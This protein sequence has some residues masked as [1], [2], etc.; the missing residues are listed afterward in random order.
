MADW[1]EYGELKNHANELGS[2]IYKKYD[3]HK[4][5]LDQMG[6]TKEKLEIRLGLKQ[7][8]L[9]KTEQNAKDIVL[10]LHLKQIL[11]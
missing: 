2:E 1:K 8:P 9:T 6:I 7:R 3:D 11:P 10:L 5:Y 4:L